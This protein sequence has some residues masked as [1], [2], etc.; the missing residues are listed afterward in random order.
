MET[1]PRAVNRSANNNMLDKGE[2]R[3]LSS[4]MRST[5]QSLSTVNGALARIACGQSN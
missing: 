1:Q 2:A 3:A 4:G 5:S